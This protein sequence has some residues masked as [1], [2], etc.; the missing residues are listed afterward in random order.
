VNKSALAVKLVVALAGLWACYYLYSWYQRNYVLRLALLPETVTSADGATVR[1]R[2][3]MEFVRVPAGR[4]KMGSPQGVSD[5][6]P[7][8]E[9]TFAKPFYM[10]KH[11]VTLVQW[12]RLMGGRPNENPTD[13][14]PVE[15]VSW[16]D[17]QEFIKKL[18]ALNDGYAYRLPSEAEWEY[19]CRAGEEG[20]YVRDLDKMAWHS[21][22]SYKMTHRVGQTKPNAFGLYDMFGNVWEWCEDNARPNYEGA[23]G[24]GKPY[25]QAQATPDATRITR[26]FSYE[27]E[28]SKLRA[29]YR[30]YAPADVRKPTIGFRLVA[31]P[32]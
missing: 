2:L 21:A 6:L 26:G 5:E 7:Q 8:H 1:N 15:R 12:E 14:A 3:G 29:A 20:D 30:G 19:A 27:G 32:R 23:P 16:H 18:N 9:V 31:T 28:L 25:Y 11:E 17:T 13:D 10:G 24:D 4:F 22:N